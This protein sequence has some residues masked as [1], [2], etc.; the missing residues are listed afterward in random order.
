M[1][2]RTSRYFYEL[3]LSL[4][5]EH[6][7]KIFEF[8]AHVEQHDLKNLAGRN[9]SSA[10]PNPHTKR[11]QAN[12]AY[13]QK[14]CLWHFHIG[15]PDY[16]GEHGDMTSEY[17]LHYK[18]LDDEIVIVDLTIHPPFKLPNENALN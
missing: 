4:S 16:V 11:Q 7:Q 5:E 2:V 9:K 17:I 3:F 10:L 15:I 8:I 6:Q 13:A 1:K 14:H 12:F 18:R